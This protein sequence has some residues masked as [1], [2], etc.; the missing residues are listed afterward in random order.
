MCGRCR[1]DSAHRRRR[2]LASAAD[3]DGYFCLVDHLKELI[4]CGGPTS[5]RAWS[6]DRSEPADGRRLAGVLTWFLARAQ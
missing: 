3:A 4:K 5:P 2:R 6:A 1:R